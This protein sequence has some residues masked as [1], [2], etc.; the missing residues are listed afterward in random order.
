MPR[1]GRPGRRRGDRGRGP[2]HASGSA[3]TTW[4]TSSVTHVHVDHAGGAGALLER[5]PRAT[6]W[7]HERGAPHL[8]DPTRLLAS[9]ARTYGDE[10]MRRFYGDDA[11]VRRGPPARRS[12]TASGS[13]LGDRAPRRRAHP[14]PRLASRC[15]ARDARAGRCSPGEAIGS[16]LPWADCYR[17]AM[18]PPEADVEAAIASIAAHARTAP[19]HAAHVA[20]RPGRAIAEAGFERGAGAHPVVVL[21]GPGSPRG[22]PAPRTATASRRCC[23]HRPRAEYEARRRLAVRSGSLRRDRVDQDE[24]RR[25]R[26][27]L[28]QA[29]GARG[30]VAQL[31][32]ASRSAASKAD[33]S[34]RTILR[35]SAAASS[36]RPAFASTSPRT[37]HSR[38]V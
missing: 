6:V 25:A 30:G 2:R 4:P 36:R 15:P 32:S 28:A 13:T 38:S 12:S 24:R 27:L 9:T 7:V 3:P 37:Y 16:H 5:F 1:R 11:A 26:P 8:V 33:A 21:D 10:R 22:R 31:S 14:G 23:A 35:N 17:P 19:E 20:L 34:W 29:M 18:P